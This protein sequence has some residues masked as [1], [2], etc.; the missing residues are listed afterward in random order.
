MNEFSELKVLVTGHTGFKGS[1]LSHALD[2]AGARVSG[3][4]LDPDSSE[5]LFGISG[6]SRLL[7][8]DIRGDI[9]DFGTCREAL[10]QIQPEVII[11]LAAQPLVLRS[12]KEPLETFDTNVMGTANILQAALDVGS[13][14]VVLVVTTDKVYGHGSST[15]GFHESDRLIASDPYGTSKVCAEFVA[16][17]F[18]ES[19]T[20]NHQDPVRIVTARAGNV[21]G[22]GDWSENR[23]VPDFVNAWM[24][25]QPMTVRHPQAVRPW[26]HV[27]EPISGYL[28]YIAEILK[29]DSKAHANALN[30]GPTSESHLSVRQLLEIL[31]SRIPADEQVEIRY[32][33][34]HALESQELRLNS[35]MANA[36]L[37]WRPK[38]SVSQ[39]IQ[40]TM[41][42]YR[43]CM[44][45]HDMYG[46]TR[47][48]IISHNEQDSATP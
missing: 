9:R 6:V 44:S 13:T 33:E 19:F 40:E 29:K 39:A 47:S 12:Y 45:G 30:F 7:E 46:Y 27:M 42:W 3:L 2:I 23:L 20:S 41:E 28:R 10:D 34:S 8:H 48:Q 22:G 31:N 37:G 17:S 4:S 43:N 11:H 32:I 36:E 14:R 35:N 25:K 18:R 5:S 1:W 26:Q 21:I 16:E 24:A 15:A 38:M